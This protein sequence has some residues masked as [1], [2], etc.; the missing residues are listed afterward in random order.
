MI[1]GALLILD[2]DYTNWVAAAICINVSLSFDCADGQLARYR[3]GSG[4]ELGSFYDK[5]S[6]ALGMILLFSIAGWACAV[7]TGEMMYLLFGTLAAAG[8]ITSGYAKWVCMTILHKRGHIEPVTDTEVPLWQYPFRIILKV[9]RFAEPDLL[10]WLGLG[11]L[12]NHLDWALWL[13]VLS[14][15]LIA[16]VAVVYYAGRVAQSDTRHRAEAA[17]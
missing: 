8:Q 16:M 12:T 6:D 13:F 2:H 3:K 10:F 17:A 5:V 1:L 15:P 4:S 14:Q 7:Q 9:F 11:L